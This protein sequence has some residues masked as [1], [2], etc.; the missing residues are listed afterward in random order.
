MERKI[1]YSFTDAEI[2][3]AV[4]KF[5]NNCLLD[6]IELLALVCGAEKW[7][8]F[9]EECEADPSYQWGYGHYHY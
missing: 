6:S 5:K 3:E 2:K 7:I 1:T 4:D 8:E 9:K